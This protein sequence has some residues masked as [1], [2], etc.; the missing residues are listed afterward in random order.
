VQHKKLI[1]MKVL[2]VCLGNICR[3]PI[4]DGLLA[5]KVSEQGLNVEVDSAGTGD[6]HV[7]EA[8]DERMRKTAKRLGTPID[9]LRARQFKVA[10]YDEF[11]LI[12]VM[13]KS[14][15]DNVVKLARNEEDKAKVKMILNEIKP[16]S[17]MEVP[18]PYW[19]G[20]QGFIDVYNMLD[21]ATDIIVNKLK[22]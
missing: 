8:P 22:N 2:M 1:E 13:D 3:S 12:Y 20:E 9:H 18:D 16:N 19:S 4:A 10:D 21:E 6:Y 5:K 17:D 11:D 7:G 14:N 15:Y